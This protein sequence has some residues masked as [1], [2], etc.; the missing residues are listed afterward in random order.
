MG[1][2]AIQS[3]IEEIKRMLVCYLISGIAFMLTI[4]AVAIAAISNS[5]GSPKAALLASGMAG[6]DFA[7]TLTSFSLPLIRFTVNR[8]INISR[9]LSL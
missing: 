9:K 8:W 7:T 2:T 6:I 5:M 3:N 4:L 1:E